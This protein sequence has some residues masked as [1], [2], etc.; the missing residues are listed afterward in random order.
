MFER[1]RTIKIWLIAVAVV[2]AIATLLTSNYLIR[3]LQHEERNRM[4]VW[5]EAMR[6]LNDADEFTDLNLVLKVINGNNTIPVIVLDRDGNVQTHRNIDRQFSADEDSIT[7]LRQMA[8]R[9]KNSGNSLRIFPN[10][11]GFDQPVG[12][13]PTEFI[14]ICYDESLML[15]RLAVYPYVQL[16]VVVIFVL[17]AIFAL[18]SSMKAE[19]NKVWVGLSKETAHQLGTPISSLMAW[20]AVLRENYPD[21]VLLPEMEKDVRRLERIAERFSKI[22]SIPEPR[23]E[24][25]G[26]VIRRVVDYMQRRT[27]NKVQMHTHLPSDPVIVNL[28]ASLFE[29]VLENLCKNAVDAMSG[30]G[31]IDITLSET[32]SQVVIEVHD[33]GKGIAKSNFGSVFKPGFT[34]KARGWGLGLSLA[35][36]IVEQYHHGRIFVKSSELG[37]GTT[38]C[39]QLPR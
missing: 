21:D 22:G 25:V 37:R 32:P 30:T 33:T 7:I 9:M 16:S 26:E 38:F 3:D 15:K 39:I 19:Q 24:D 11:Q 1:I 6:S 8:R 10:M 5:A 28:V 34:T 31:S 29:W 12:Q 35:K 20:S 2:I 23:P 13:Q 36:R 18:F 4:E 27:S 14:E 17:I